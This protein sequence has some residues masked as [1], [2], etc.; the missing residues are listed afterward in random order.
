MQQQIDDVGN[1]CEVECEEKYV[2]LDGDFGCGCCYVVS[3]EII[4]KFGQCGQENIGDELGEGFVYI[5]NE[6]CFDWCQ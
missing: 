6:Q 5:E 2:G 1:G 4:E 3:Q